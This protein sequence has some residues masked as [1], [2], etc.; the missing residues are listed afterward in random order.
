M[1]WRF[2]TKVLGFML[3]TTEV[4]IIIW[5][6]IQ[7]LR[8][9]PVGW[10]RSHL[11][12]SLKQTFLVR[13]WC[14]DA[15]TVTR[16]AQRVCIVQYAAM[17]LLRRIMVGISCCDR[18]LLLS[19][20]IES[21]AVTF[22]NSHMGGILINFAANFVEFHL[23]YKLVQIFSYWTQ[24]SRISALSKPVRLIYRPLV[25]IKDAWFFLTTRS[26][27]CMLRLIVVQLFNVCDLWAWGSCAR[28]ISAKQLFCRMF[29]SQ[30][31]SRLQRYKARLLNV[32]SN[33]SFMVILGIRA[34]VHLLVVLGERIV[35][36]LRN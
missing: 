16:S 20:I 6:V 7:I 35:S 15:N 25:V 14:L 1:G 31:R 3:L 26:F 33:H 23:A 36:G 8:I 19:A 4:L 29:C 24:M 27:C 2:T 28:N 30:Q 13:N 9:S 11:S 32:S 12:N 34:V 21:L 22:N 18:L 5:R 10:C 17:K